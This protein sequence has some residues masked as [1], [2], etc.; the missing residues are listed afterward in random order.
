MNSTS[1]GGNRAHNGSSIPRASRPAHPVR[2]ASPAQEGRRPAPIDAVGATLRRP[3]LAIPEGAIGPQ[4]S[5]LRDRCRMVGHRC[6]S[7]ATRNWKAAIHGVRR[8]GPA[9]RTARKSDRMF[10]LARR[11]QID[12]LRTRR[13]IQKFRSRALRHPAQYREGQTRNS[14]VSRATSSPN[15]RSASVLAARPRAK[16]VCRLIG[17]LCARDFREC[18]FGLARY[19]GWMT[20]AL[21]HEFLEWSVEYRQCVQSRARRCNA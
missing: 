7:T 11:A 1:T 15:S 18:P 21:D 14:R 20:E 3:P 2:R 17:E 6:H 19:L 9:R 4:N 10:K 12:A 8:A 5:K 16:D 13:T